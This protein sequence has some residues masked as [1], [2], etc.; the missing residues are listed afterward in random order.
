MPIR[1][2]RDIEREIVRRGSDSGLGA[3]QRVIDRE[4]V[5]RICDG[6]GDAGRG[7]VGLDRCGSR[8]DRRDQEE[9]RSISFCFMSRRNMSGLPGGWVGCC[10]RMRS[11][12]AEP[13]CALRG[14]NPPPGGSHGSCSGVRRRPPRADWLMPQDRSRYRRGVRGPR[15]RTVYR[16]ALRPGTRRSRGSV[17]RSTRH[18]AGR[19]P[20]PSASQPGLPIERRGATRLRGCSRTRMPRNARRFSMLGAPMNLSCHPLARRIC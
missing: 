17:R 13:C 11:R 1:A 14:R 10:D 9:E 4:P 7:Q 18:R 6:A 20:R 12:R 2:G 16:T 8:R 5:G 19:W 3:G 15:A